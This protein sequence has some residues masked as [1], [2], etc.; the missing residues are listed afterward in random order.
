IW[1]LGIYP[2][3]LA[4]PLIYKPIAGNGTS[5]GRLAAAAIVS[6]LIA[7]QLGAL[8]VVLETLLSGK[9]ELSFGS[10][11]L[12]MQPI[13]LAI[14]LVEG[15]V[16]AGI[17]SYIKKVRPEIIQFNI[18][19]GHP[20]CGIPIK[21]IVI[22][23]ALLAVIT[24]GAL[25]WFASTNPDGLEWSLEKLTGKGELAGHTQG[26][27]AVMKQI[28]EKTAFLP[29]YNFKSANKEKPEKGKEAAWPGVETGTS[30]AGIVGGA[31]VLSMIVL[32]GF[33]LR[34]FKKRQE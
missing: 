24:G 25:S 21:K 34:V 29:D 5:T 6:A 27:P 26:I 28:Q 2:C 15:F 14:G 9:S 22:T 7:L 3:F 4:Y 11:I 10:F 13:H 32:F 12:L 30:V 23:F 1:N 8:S 19:T 16:T 18:S 33:V 17:I 31:I 20:A